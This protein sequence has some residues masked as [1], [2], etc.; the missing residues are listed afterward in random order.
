[1]H[2]GVSLSLRGI[3]YS[4]NS[5]VSIS[6][7]GEG[8]DALL[9]QTDKTQ[10]CRMRDNLPDRVAFGQWFFPNGDEVGND[11]GDFF[12][13]RGEGIVRLNRR[14]NALSPTGRYRCVIPDASGV[15]QTLYVDVGE[16]AYT[17]THA[18]LFPPLHVY[19]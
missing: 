6:D 1:M 11:D 17:L 14:N 13:N 3:T 12:R 19:P 2:G 18:A 9:C 10:C 7:I 15:N 5:V 8:E 4:N 16:K